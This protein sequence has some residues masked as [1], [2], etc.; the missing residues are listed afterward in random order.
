MFRSLMTIM[1]ELYLYLTEVIL[2]VKTLGK[3]TSLYILGDVVGCSRAACVLCAVQ[4]ETAVH[5]C[6]VLCRVRL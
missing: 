1:T 4:S 3:I 6:C 2:N 5:V